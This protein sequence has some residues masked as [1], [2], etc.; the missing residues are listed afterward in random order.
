MARKQSVKNF[1]R[2]YLMDGYYEII[3][4]VCDD[5][6][7]S[8]AELFRKALVEYMKNH[9][10]ADMSKLPINARDAKRARRVENEPE[11]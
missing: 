2:I 11:K 9:N 5:L 6:G 7:I 1:R 3:Q 10:L 4:K 8:E